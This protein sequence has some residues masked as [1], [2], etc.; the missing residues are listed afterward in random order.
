[1]KVSACFYDAD[2]AGRTGAK[3]CAEAAKRALPHVSVRYYA[4]PDVEGKKGYDV[5]DAFQEGGRAGV[6]A[7]FHR[8]YKNEIEVKEAP[9][10][11]GRVNQPGRDPNR[12]YRY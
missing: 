5:S 11:T 1:M 8:H 7:W 10:G 9:T 12:L 3:K 4:G 2:D 6:I